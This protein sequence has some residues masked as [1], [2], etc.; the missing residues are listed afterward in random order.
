MA[1]N[2]ESN[3]AS[4]ERRTRI[5]ST[6]IETA[7]ALSYDPRQPR[8]GRRESEPHSEEITYL[9]DVLRAN[10]PES[11][12]M[13]DLH[14]YFLVGSEVVDIQFDISF[15]KNFKIEYSLSSYRAAKFNNRVPDMVINFLSKSTWHLDVGIHVDYC[16]LLKIP[17][18]IVF[19]PFYIGKPIY[20]PPFLR[21]YILQSSGDYR[22]HDLQ[23]IALKQGA[24]VA[25]REAVLDVSELVPFN[26]GIMALNTRHEGDLPRYRLVLVNVKNYE[27][28][29]TR[30]EQ[31]KAR[32]E[33]EK[34]RADQLQ[35]QLEALQ[36]K[37]RIKDKEHNI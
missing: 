6:R 27:I 20:K 34:A 16:R 12:A 14:H 30:A 8:L 10:F 36:R 31:E 1:D 26:V 2:A 23:K 28:Y 5:R 9:Y 13:W 35:R 15:F 17:L 24:T 18:Y 21:A 37:L 22:I 19:S 3:Q 32:A 7:E 11:R 4:V 33:Q 25:N 29:L